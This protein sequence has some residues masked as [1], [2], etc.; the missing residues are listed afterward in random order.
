MEIGR[1]HRRRQP[2]R[3]FVGAV[4]TL[5]IGGLVGTQAVFAHG[6]G[7]TGEH[8]SAGDVEQ[9]QQKLRDAG[10]DPGAIDGRIGRQTRQAVKKFQQANDLETNGRL[11]RRT[12]S[13]LGVEREGA[14]SGTRGG[15][16]GRKMDQGMQEP[17]GMPTPAPRGGPEP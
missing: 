5:V 7:R 4:A 15:A 14:T 1:T 6:P 12:L 17:R 8:A 11:D 9:A 3:A 10:Y 16:S 2:M 13:A